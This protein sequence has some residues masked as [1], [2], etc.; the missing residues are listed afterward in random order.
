MEKEIKMIQIKFNKK[1]MAIMMIMI[2]KNKKK[3]N[4]NLLDKLDFKID[5]VMI[6]DNIQHFLILIVKLKVISPNKINFKI[7]IRIL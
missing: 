5:R 6:L 4:F 3:I 2:S 1:V 7:K